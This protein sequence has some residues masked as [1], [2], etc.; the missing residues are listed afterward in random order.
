[1]QGRNNWVEEV[2]HVL[3]AYRAMIKTSDKDTPF[4]LT[5]GTEAVISVERGMP[6][7]R[8]A[9]VYQV[10]N[11]EALML[12]L[13][14]LE[15]KRERAAIREA[16]SKAKNGKKNTTTLRSAVKPLSQETFYTEAMKLA[17]RRKTE[18][19]AQNEK[20]RTK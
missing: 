19:W 4:F 20:D 15:E 17:M 2:P 10:W 3:W 8:C 13:Y 7:L 12:N 14:M 18:N 16:K 5:Y 6:S 9:K 1:D 11:D